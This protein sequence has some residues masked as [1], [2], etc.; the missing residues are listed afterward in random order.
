MSL[1]YSTKLYINL[2]SDVIHRFHKDASVYESLV[3]GAWSKKEHYC[4]WVSSVIPQI[5]CWKYA[6]SVI[7]KITDNQSD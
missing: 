4:F 1:A 6:L 5:S 7:K 3:D 2:H